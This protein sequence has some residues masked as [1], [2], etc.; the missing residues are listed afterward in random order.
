MQIQ[1][2]DGRKIKVDESRVAYARKFIDFEK[3]M[4]NEAPYDTW[5]WRSRLSTLKEE[6][7][8]IKRNKADRKSARVAIFNNNIIGVGGITASHSKFSKHVGYAGYVIA[9]EFR[10]TGLTYFLINDS[11]KYVA[12]K[13]VKTVIATIVP[14]NKA[15]IKLFEKCGAKRI[16]ESKK[17]LFIPLKNVYYNE[18]YMQVDSQKLITKSANKYK[19]KGVKILKTQ[20]V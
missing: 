4:K 7:N 11:A 16:G 9:K 12:K 20:P 14:Q 3:K 6:I 13:G 5:G 15:S 19:Q 1:L 2:K 17:T 8:F 18:I 10:G